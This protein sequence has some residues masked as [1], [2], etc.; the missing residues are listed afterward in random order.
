[1]PIPANSADTPRSDDDVDFTLLALLLLF[2][3][4]LL[5]YYGRRQFCLVLPTTPD[6]GAQAAAGDA[7]WFSSRIHVALNVPAINAPTLHGDADTVK[8]LFTFPQHACHF[9]LRADMEEQ[10]SHY[11]AAEHAYMACVCTSSANSFVG[12]SCEKKNSLPEKRR[13]RLGQGQGAGR[14]A[15]QPS[16]IHICVCHTH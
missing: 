12:S 8:K 13:E 11:T 3:H 6:G 14:G 5:F 2:F 16:S 15:E 7:P 9:Y 4:L 1:M 10:T